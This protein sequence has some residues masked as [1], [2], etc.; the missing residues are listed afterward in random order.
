MPN[1][2]K[3]RLEGRRTLSRGLLLAFVAAVPAF[4]KPVAPD[5]RALARKAAEF[6]GAPAFTNLDTLHFTFNVEIGD[7]VRSRKWSWLVALDS[8]V[9]AGRFGAGLDTVLGFSRGR[10]ADS[11]QRQTDQWFVNDSYWL[12]FPCHLAWDKGLRLSAEA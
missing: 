2:P 7:T 12:L 3:R 4:S 10:P 6:C 11:L 8:V 1:L 9:Y 5:A